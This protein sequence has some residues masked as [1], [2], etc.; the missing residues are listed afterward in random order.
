M[1]QHPFQCPLRVRVPCWGTSPLLRW[2]DPSPWLAQSTIN[3]LLG[4]GCG[5]SLRLRNRFDQMSGNDRQIGSR[6]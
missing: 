1:L 3:A 2:A 5:G 4:L 6:W